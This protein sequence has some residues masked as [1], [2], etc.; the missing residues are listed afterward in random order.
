MVRMTKT[1]AGI[2]LLTCLVVGCGGSG[3]SE[4]S[5]D[6]N[7]RGRDRSIPTTAE[8]PAPT[9]AEPP[10]P[11][12]VD[13]QGVVSTD[14][15]AI[16][17][18]GLGY[19][20]G[21]GVPICASINAD[22]SLA[23]IV[24]VGG[25]GRLIN[26]LDATVDDA[27]LTPGQ[28]L[29]LCGVFREGTSTNEDAFAFPEHPVLCAVVNDGALRAGTSTVSELA[30]APAVCLNRDTNSVALHRRGAAAVPCQVSGD[31]ADCRA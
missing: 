9:A 12:S 11:T 27:S 31:V 20:P 30:M 13:A 15:V 21:Y 3:T 4:T 10:I 29:I 2:A 18:D 8:T 6:S 16:P 28:Y 7:R 17:I 1:S 26:C 14:C 22:G 25:G 5:G 23:T 24:E 19:P